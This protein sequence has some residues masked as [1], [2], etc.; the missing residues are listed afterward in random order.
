MQVKHRI[1]LIQKPMLFN[2]KSIKLFFL[3]VVI[4][5]FSNIVE[6]ALLELKNQ[7]I[8]IIGDPDTGRFIFKTTGGDPDLNT[9]QDS[10]LLYE[11]YPPT[12]FTTLKIDGVNYKFGD[13]EKGR[14]ATSMISRNNRLMCVWK[15]GNIE[16][17]QELKFVKGPTTGRDDTVEISY[18][19]INKD[20]REHE[21][22][23]RI[24]MD[25]YLGK[26]DGAP[27][28]VPGL[29]DIKTE[30][31]LEGSKIP[32]YWYSYDDLGEPS[33]RAQGTLKAKDITP[34]DR[35]IFSS[36][37]RFQKYLWDFRIKPGRSFRRSVIGPL[38]S[39][40]AMYWNPKK[41]APNGTLKVKTYYGLYG[42]SIYKGKVFN[43]SL[44]GPVTTSGEPFLV[45][46]DVQNVSPRDAK[47][48]TAEIILPAGLKLVVGE[49]KT[50]NLATLRKSEIKK[51][52]WNIIPDKT[53]TGFI[54]FKV[55]VTGTVDNKKETAVA[56]RKIEY[57][58]KKVEVTLYDFS[59]LNKLL[60]QVNDNLG[61]NN[62][63]LVKINKLLELEQ[64]K[65]EDADND[66]EAVKNR[67][68]KIEEIKKEINNAVK[69]AL[70]KQ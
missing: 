45:T 7:Y 47:N 2:K 48:T 23:V 60:Q 16:A 12:S 24:M 11:D 58:G 35:I 59:A 19:I 42:A 14:F 1:M 5:F 70:K 4:L 40:I 38:D 13:T 3:L 64:K 44:G 37:E 69:A 67:E 29:G 15:V 8:K 10:L 18:T 21:I 6:G 46:A 52:A 27:F 53:V 9:D 51:V 43:I 36:W 39:A 34:P 61:L 62:E 63:L 68:N 65:Y 30:T 32:Q 41:V 49:N 56:E 26:E 25:T 54:T 31:V 28:R 66:I 55:K 50:K 17:M 57:K 22:G 20:S 33:V